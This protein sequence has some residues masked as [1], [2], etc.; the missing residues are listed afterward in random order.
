MGFKVG[1][2]GLPNVGKST[3]FKALTKKQV[4]IA[5]Y[6]FATI[7][8]NVG[9]VE[10]PD[11]RLEK[12][13]AVSHSEKIIP[14]II[15]FY[16]IAGLVAGAYRGEGLGNQFLAHIREVEAIVHVVRAFSD[17]NV[18]HVY[19]SSNPQRDIEII[20]L[21]L[22][23]ADL[24][25]V[26]RRLEGVSSQAKSGDKEA[27]KMKNLL[28]KVKDGLNQGKMAREVIANDEE[29]L[30]L[31]ELHL[32][33]MK[34]VLYVFNVDEGVSQSLGKKLNIEPS[35]EISA[36]I[37]AELADLPEKEARELMKDLGMKESGLDRLIIA[38]YKLLD[39]ITFFTSGPK[40][41]RA[42]TVK[43]GTKAPQAAG[44]IH[45]DFERGFIRVEV[46][47]WRDFVECGGETGAK[48][49]GLMRLEG[50]DYLIQDG[51]VC[52]FRFAV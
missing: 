5:N 29:R 22:C 2:I 21:E 6:P 46:I 15:E 52:Y 32:L 9:V 43:R 19:Q 47:N 36:K 50:K 13:A 27:I 38:S 26:E 37:E 51:D 30:S 33:T 3:L 31:Q 48:E 17:P 7:A 16:D 28:E 8:P 20:N 25:T 39:L 35:L 49:K 34:P 45:S 1:I 4:L 41:S 40:E 12:L 44:V 18:S 10:V 14:T 23:L 11:E 42:W 24:K